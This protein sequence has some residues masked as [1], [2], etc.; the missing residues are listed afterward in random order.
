MFAPT[1]QRC[2]L[3][4]R[5]SKRDN[6]GPQWMKEKD[7][8]VLSRTTRHR[9]AVCVAYSEGQWTS[10]FEKESARAMRI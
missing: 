7:A 6:V 3:S 8:R 10:F 1:V 4:F 2:L 5:P 9:M